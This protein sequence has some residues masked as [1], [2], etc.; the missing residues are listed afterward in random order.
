MVQIIPMIPIVPMFIIEYS[1]ICNMIPLLSLD[2]LF[3]V[4]MLQ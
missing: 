3:H 2:K 4:L 1:N